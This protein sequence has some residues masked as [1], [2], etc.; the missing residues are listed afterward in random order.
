MFSLVQHTSVNHGR[1]DAFMA[2]KPLDRMDVGTHFKGMRGKRISKGVATHAFNKSGLSHCLFHYPLKN[3]FVCMVAAFLVGPSVLPM[4]LLKKNPL[5][6]PPDRGV[7]IFSAQ[8][9]GH[10]RS[11]PF[12]APVPLVN[13]CNLPQMLSLEQNR[14]RRHAVFST[15]R[16]RSLHSTLPALILN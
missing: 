15:C 16:N 5:L 7:G 4:L 9:I 12:F 1:A 3:R 13:R 10:L 11:S 2:Q 6:S 14:Q 8:G